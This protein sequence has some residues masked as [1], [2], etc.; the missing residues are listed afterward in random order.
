MRAWCCL[1]LAV[2]FAQHGSSQ[3]EAA[4]EPVKRL[5]S[6]YS[7]AKALSAA[8]EERYYENERLLRTESGQVYFR[9]PGKMRWDYQTPEEKVFVSDGR[10]VWLYVP[11]D[12]T[13]MRTPVKE[14]ADW[15]TPFSLLT[16][17]PR[18]A[19]LCGSVRVGNAS[20]AIAAGNKVLHCR[21]RHAE[22]EPGEYQEIV[23][24]LNA[25]TGELSRVKILQGGGTAIEFFF[26]QWTE[27]ASLGEAQFHFVP[28]RGVA[29]VEAGAGE[30][31]LKRRA[32]P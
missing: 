28:P 6:R 29:I 9:R 12:R 30:S 4:K 17:S 15:R 7:T 3:D 8:F 1:L 31:G 26:S 14:S 5:E 2:V 18:L 10:T 25:R 27:D 24:E 11:A 32:A 16:R 19:R 20:E 13:A 21:P 22:E 23:I